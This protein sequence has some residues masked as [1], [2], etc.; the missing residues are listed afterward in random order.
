VNAA[1]VSAVLRLELQALRRE[2]LVWLC[3]LVLGVVAATFTGAG[4]IEL[5]ADRGDVPRSSPWSLALACTAIAAFGQVLTTMVSATAVLRDE[6]VRLTPLLQAT[7]LSAGE[8]VLGKLAAT[9]IALTVVYAAVP[10]GMVVGAT[11]QEPHAPAVWQIVASWAAIGLPVMLAVATLQVSVAALTGRLWA[12]VGVGLVL[13]WL[14][15][16]SVDAAR[17]GTAAVW[18][19]AVD[20]F[21]SAPIVA[22]TTHWTPAQ[23]ASSFVALTS[24]YYAGRIVW[25]AMA[26]LTLVL[27]LRNRWR[28]RELSAA[29]PIAMVHEPSDRVRPWPT[30][31]AVPSAR[32]VALSSARV[33]W[34]W[35]TRDVGFRVLLLLGA[36]NVGVHTWIDVTADAPADTQRA[37]AFRALLV[38]S[39]LFLILL[40]TI[41]AGE[42]V[43]RAREVRMAGLLDA[44]P[45]A[46][47]ARA[48]GD[49]LG[50]LAAQGCTC[51]ALTL[52]VHCLASLAAQRW[53]PTAAWSLAMLLS[54]GLVFGSWMLA[55]V[56]V[57]VLVPQKVVA[58][59]LLI[60]GWTLA[61]ARTGG[62]TEGVW[63]T[64]D[65][66][67]PDGV[68]A[69][70]GAIPL[71]QLTGLVA[72]LGV[73]LV[74]A[75]L[76]VGRER[77][78]GR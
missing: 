25:S 62:G 64:L 24:G 50:T 57:H 69:G 30:V 49:L 59:L 47:R 34:R 11:M 13:L 71:V 76:A 23:R 37:V 77:G 66:P 38:H 19:L 44:T 52:L 55:S 32:A 12:V 42:V 35:I 53:L 78:R 4:P 29:R 51:V 3:A 73:S 58:H 70:T 1:R 15:S 28:P 8:A 46:R 20:P 21:A 54:P 65:W 61:V 14:W 10:L 75:V 68:L 41:Y 60:A 48:A 17:S 45:G 27:A 43:W 2:P 67:W 74:V 5:V 63:R 18:A 33:T 56:L 40:A 72:L 31:A 22:A 36:F 26:V 7:R 6:A 9:L 39:R 16:A